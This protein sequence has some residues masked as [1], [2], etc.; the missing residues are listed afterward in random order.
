MVATTLLTCL[1]TFIKRLHDSN[2]TN[3]FA[4]WI[5]CGV[6]ARPHR[7]IFL[8]SRSAGVPAAKSNSSPLNIFSDLYTLSRY[9]RVV[10]ISRHRFY[11]NYYIVHV[12]FFS[13][14]IS[15][16]VSRRCADH[17]Y[18]CYHHRSASARQHA[19]LRTLHAARPVTSCL[20]T[21]DVTSDVTTDVTRITASSHAL[22]PGS[23]S[24]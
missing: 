6:I 1:N 4:E 15:S 19:G 14:Y 7:V 10:T 21:H 20:L 12:L 18:N 8:T 13:W 2:K 17:Y 24:G 23:L 5:L 16:F 9:T 11:H 3:K 22:F